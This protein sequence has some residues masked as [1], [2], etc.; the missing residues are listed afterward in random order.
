MVM[1]RV[2]IRPNHSEI[3]QISNGPAVSSDPDP[4]VNHV[5][6]SHIEVAG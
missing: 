2:W 5:E 3:G 4:V 6:L 1:I